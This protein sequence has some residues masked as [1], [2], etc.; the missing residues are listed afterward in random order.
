MTYIDK[1]I[2]KIYCLYSQRTIQL[3][4]QLIN[5]RSCYSQFYGRTFALSS[6]KLL[7]T[8][9]A[10]ISTAGIYFYLLNRSK[11]KLCCQEVIDD[12]GNGNETVSIKAIDEPKQT[13]IESNNRTHS[14]SVWTTIF[15]FLKPDLVWLFLSIP[16]NKFFS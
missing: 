12:N 14:L 7:I 9:G 16:V 5:H 11:L 1:I 8:S 3:R 13:E 15:H 6:S 10:T 2:F 4:T